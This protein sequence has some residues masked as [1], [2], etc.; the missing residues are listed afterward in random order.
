MLEAETRYP[1][2]SVTWMYYETRDPRNFRT[3]PFLQA[4]ATGRGGTV[5]WAVLVRPD[6][7]IPWPVLAH[8]AWGLMQLCACV[9]VCVCVCV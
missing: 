3:F 8:G 2:L 7:V 9:C 5:G 4:G 6:L 1:C